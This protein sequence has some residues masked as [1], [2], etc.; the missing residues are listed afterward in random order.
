MVERFSM[1]VARFPTNLDAVLVWDVDWR[2]W[3]E[4]LQ[5]HEDIMERGEYFSDDST[6]EG[7]PDDES[8]GDD[9]AVDASMGD[10]STG[11]ASTWYHGGV[12]TESQVELSLVPT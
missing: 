4:R 7:S 12:A 1:V 3:P 5:E 11:D 9:A 6:D 8:L 2:L 10:A